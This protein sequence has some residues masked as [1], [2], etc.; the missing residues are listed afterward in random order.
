MMFNI[1]SY[2]IS[3]IQGTVESIKLIL[4]DGKINDSYALTRK[5]H[6]SV[7]INIY[8]TLYLKDNFN[9][10]NFVVK[11]INDWVCDK[12]DL[13]QYRD[14]MEYICKSKALDRVNKMLD[15]GLKGHYHNIRNKCNDHTHYNLF[16]YMMLN[17]NQIYLMDRLKFLDELS[18]D[19]RD[20]FILHFIWLFTLNGHYMA[21]SDYRDSLECGITPE[22]DS[23]YWIAPF[24]QKV[25][26]RIIKKYRI[27][28]ATEL[29]NTTCMKLE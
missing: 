25:F 20:I 5:F 7:V 4:K 1:D 17:D 15:V 19:I 14:M 10:D 2:L 29:K 9:I 27:D 16:Y 6:E 18:G 24:V 3:S 21:S 22:E 23:Q 8:E 13:P 12:E 11:K 28:L 26:D